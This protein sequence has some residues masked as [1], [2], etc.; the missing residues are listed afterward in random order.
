MT[1]FA[2]AHGGGDVGWSWHLVAEA[3][4][5]KGHTVV[6][7]DLPIEDEAKDLTDWAQALTE[8][9]PSTEDVVVVGHSFGGF[10]AP[11]AA[12]RVN[13]K[14]LV[15]VTAMIPSP[16][17]NPGDWWANTGYEDP[18]LED[19]FFH[20]VPPALA[21]EAQKRERG[22]AE[23]PMAKPWP[24]DKMPDLPTHF[25]LCTEDRFFTPNFMRKVVADRLGVEPVELAAGHC[26][27]L[28][29]PNEL[30]DL[31]ANYAR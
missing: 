3:L 23:S 12:A 6:A 26:A 5:A 11:L 21:A 17:E 8:A 24:L 25:I 18:G 20:D 7:P 31:L 2:I 27:S 28:S 10:V 14:A 4:Q 19:A 29:K 30:A 15:Y 13:A 9:L 16:G 1:T 22:M